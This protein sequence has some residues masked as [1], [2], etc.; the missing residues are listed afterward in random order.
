MAKKRKPAADTTAV[1]NKRQHAAPLDTTESFRL[2]DLPPEI[3]NTIYAIVM[4][5]EP[6][7]YLIP[8][9]HGKPFCKS[10]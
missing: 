4:A 3:R 10:R 5:E 2:L 6:Q 7:A 8:S 9:N 1:S